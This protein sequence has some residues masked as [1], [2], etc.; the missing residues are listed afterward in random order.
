M[1]QGKKKVIQ[2]CNMVGRLR[3]GNTSLVTIEQQII[4]KDK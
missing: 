3:D 1:Q 4:F 2:F